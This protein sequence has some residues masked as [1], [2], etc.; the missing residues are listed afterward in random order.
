M[1]M[2]TTVCCPEAIENRGDCGKLEGT[3]PVSRGSGEIS[4]VDQW[5]KLHTPVQ[6]LGF[7]SGQAE[8]MGSHITAKDPACYKDLAELK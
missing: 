7:H 6:G 1:V 2:A 8:A 5:L 3:C 4:L